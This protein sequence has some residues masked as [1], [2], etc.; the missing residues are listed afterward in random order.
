MSAAV[1]VLAINFCVAGI[2]ATTFAVVAVYARTAIS[3]R[4][5][6]AAYGMGSLTAVLEFFLPFQSDA[7]PVGIAIFMTCLIALGL[8]VVGLARLYRVPRPWWSL[9]VVVAASAVTIVMI[10]DMERSSFV[11][12]MLYQ[13]PYSVMQALGVLMILRAPRRQALDLLL[14]ALYTVSSMHFLFKPILAEAIGSG[15]TPQAYIGS[16]YAAISQAVGAILLVANG[17]LMLLIILRDSMADMTERSETDALSG[18]LNRRGFEIRAEKMLTRAARIGLPVTILMADLDHFK[19]VNDNY[20]HAAGDKVIAAFAE[21]LRNGTDKRS[22]LGRLG[23]EEFAALVPGSTLTSGRV[24]AQEVRLDYAGPALAGLTP[25]H[26]LSVS[27]GVA[28][29][30]GNEGLFEMMRR[31]D[32]ALYEAK[33]TGRDRVCVAPSATTPEP[34]PAATLD[35]RHGSRRP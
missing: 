21:V 24:C 20:G 27:L 1:F 23:G 10:Y 33:R 3:A 28:Q 34:D 29:R 8:S 18:L 25:G 6:A 26:Q 17:L 7:R 12:A 15:S 16:T 35:Q 22:V 5:L 30:H 13:L 9:G 11:R 31:A 2:F 4:W 32:A 19:S 14:L